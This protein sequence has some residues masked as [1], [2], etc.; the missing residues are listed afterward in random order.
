MVI[1]DNLLGRMEIQGLRVLIF[2]QMSRALN[3]LEAYCLFRQNGEYPAFVCDI[4]VIKVSFTL[5]TIDID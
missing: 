2:S 5:A 3:I 1:L 4:D